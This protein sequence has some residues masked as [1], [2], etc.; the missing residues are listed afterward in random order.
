[1]LHT[2]WTTHYLKWG[3]WQRYTRSFAD[4]QTETAPDEER[5][6]IKILNIRE[7]LK[8]VLIE[9]PPPSPCSFTEDWKKGRVGGGGR[10]P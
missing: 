3:R 2:T 4:R 8:A 1:M 7:K 6:I 5:N 9:M 10:M